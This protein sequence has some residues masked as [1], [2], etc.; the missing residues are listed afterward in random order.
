VRVRSAKLAA[1][2][3][4]RR[5]DDGIRRTRSGISPILIAAAVILA[6]AIVFVIQNTRQASVQFLFI[7]RR[8]SVWVVIAIS[9]ALGVILDRL[10]TL[11]WRRRHRDDD[12]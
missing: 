3:E 2:Y 6:A 9:I 8:L 1:V 10:V 4:E 12:R 7:D 11:W 5:N